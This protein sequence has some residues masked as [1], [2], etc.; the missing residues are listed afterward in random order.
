MIDTIIK[1]ENTLNKVLKD[2]RSANNLEHLRSYLTIDQELVT[3]EDGSLTIK[4]GLY[5]VH[6]NTDTPKL[7]HTPILTQ[8]V[9]YSKPTVTDPS[10]ELDVIS[11]KIF[12]NIIDWMINSND[13][14]KKIVDGTYTK[15]L[16]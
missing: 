9:L 16:D 3:T 10:M 1:L 6:N 8:T 7:E 13:D 4:M 11:N 2:T 15:E 12:D 14:F 5:F